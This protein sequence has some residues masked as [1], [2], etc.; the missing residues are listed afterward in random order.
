MHEKE[1]EKIAETRRS[2]LEYCWLDTY[3]MVKIIE[4]L[5]MQLRMQ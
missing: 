2:L 3:G 4:K 5:Q 1:P